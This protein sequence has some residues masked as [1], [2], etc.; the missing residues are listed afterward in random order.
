MRL[1]VT[2][3]EATCWDRKTVAPNEYS[4]L[5]AKQEIIEIGCCFVTISELQIVHK[6]GIIVR[7]IFY[8]QLS[9][10]CKNL[11]GITQL[12]VDS[13]APFA[14]AVASWVGLAEKGDLFCSWGDF[15]RKILEKNCRLLGVSYPWDNHL[16]LKKLVAEEL[17]LNPASISRRCNELNVPFVGKRHRGLDDAE[18]IVSILEALCE[19]LFEDFGEILSRSLGENHFKS[20]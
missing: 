7:P 16:N 15:D 12:E 2:D 19:R 11:T 20:K 3:F 10:F 8:P 18:N 4:A 5:L 1:V 6:M 9:D 14:D 17:N 13:G